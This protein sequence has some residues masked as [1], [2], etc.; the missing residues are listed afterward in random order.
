VDEEKKSESGGEEVE[1]VGP[2]RLHEQVPQ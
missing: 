1:Q 2:Y